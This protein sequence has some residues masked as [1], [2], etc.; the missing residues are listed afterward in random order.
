MTKIGEIE[1]L[2]ALVTVIASSGCGSG[3]ACEI[4][5]K[6]EL[7]P[8]DG[9]TRICIEY[10]S[11]A[12]EMECEASGGTGVSGCPQDGV[13]GTCEIPMPDGPATGYYYDGSVELS[14][15]RCA[16]AHGVWTAP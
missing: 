7:G 9:P 3:H 4:K 15:A 12:D 1:V 2:G 10:E 13:I 14:Q 5:L 16:A 11:L 8:L 6:A